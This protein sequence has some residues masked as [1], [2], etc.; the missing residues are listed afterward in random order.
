[1]R[2]VDVNVLVY[3]H[4]SDLDEHLA[5]KQLL[6]ELAN[7]D[8]RLG[9]AEPVLSG[10]LRV[11]TNRRIFVEPTR[12]SEAWDQVRA[13]LDAPASFRVAAGGGHWSAFERLSASIDA[14][15]NDVADAYLAAFAIDHNAAWLSA[16]RGFARFPGLRWMHPL[17]SDER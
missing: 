6:V 15:G 16:D 3:A 10:Y 7:A 8:E 9:L 13:L 4:R 2:F 1:M 11:V 17:D 12:A 14:T 5:Y